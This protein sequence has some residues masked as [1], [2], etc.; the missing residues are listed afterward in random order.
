[1]H[2]NQAEYSATENSMGEDMTNNN[3]THEMQRAP[4]VDQAQRRS[5]AY[6]GTAIAAVGLAAA[7]AL[8]FK[9]GDWW[10]SAA[11]FAAVLVA[12]RV[13]SDLRNSASNEEFLGRSVPV[14][15]GIAFLLG[16]LYAMRSGWL[17]GAFSA[18]SA[19]AF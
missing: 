4:A 8:G 3:D 10:I 6:F 14:A 5:N 7:M 16:A 2:T 18:V 17:T 11:L 15:I 19:G 13:E 12:L 9:T 1:M